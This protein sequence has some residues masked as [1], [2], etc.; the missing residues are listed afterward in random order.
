VAHVDLLF[1]NDVHAS[2]HV[3]WLDPKKVRRTTI[4]GSRKMVVYDDVQTLEKVRIYDKGVDAPPHTSGFGEFQLSYRYGNIT[5]PHLRSDEPLQIECDHFLQC[6]SSE[7]APLTDGPHGLK[8]VQ[9][10]EAAQASLNEGGAIQPVQENRAAR[11]NG[12]VRSATP[13]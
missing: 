7:T 9:V 11:T 3:S 6:I 4:V 5:I 2:I 10:L 12:F 8:V 13:W 1:P